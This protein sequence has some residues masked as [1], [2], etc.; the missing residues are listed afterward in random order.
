[1]ADKLA[2]NRRVV[3]H[4]NPGAKVLPPDPPAPPAPTADPEPRPE[5]AESWRNQVP[6]PIRAPAAELPVPESFKLDNGLTVYLARQP[7]L[8][9]ATV[10]LTAHSGAAR[11]PER[12]PGLASFTAEMLNEGAGQLSTLE[13]ANGVT[14]LGSTLE[15]GSSRE[16]GWVI[17]QSL[18]PNLAKTIEYLSDVAL[19]PAF[20]QAEIDRVRRE[21]LAALQQQRSQPL[22]TAFKV[23]WREHYGDAHPYGYVELGT[24]QALNAITRDD[25]LASYRAAFTPANSALILTGDLSMKEARSLAADTFGSW[26]GEPPPAAQVPPPVPSPDRVLLVDRPGAPQTSL[27]LSQPGLARD[28]PDWSKLQLVNR[29][30]GGLFSSRLNQNLR[31]RF[32][33]TYGVD[34]NMTQGTQPGLLFVSLSVDRQQTGASVRE[35]MAE[36]ARL[37]EGG[38]TEIELTEARQSVLRS[39]PTMYRTNGSTASSIAHLYALDLPQDYYRG[40]DSRLRAV[41][42]DDTASVARRYLNPDAVKVVAIGD[43]ASVESQLSVVDLGPV[44]L[45]NSDGLP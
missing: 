13:I 21:R 25:L 42:T 35:V 15:T 20:P 39:L 10:Q 23:M 1:M 29:V 24:E 38:I 40:L 27:V 6:G 43:R 45:R 12:L 33:F 19:R 11:D 44:A 9:L 28:D 7:A 18:K 34:S 2:P 22:T 8:P 36:L 17:A 4:A 30:L 32:G 26:R 3:V 41:T 16:A 31:E 5:P 14:A 37:K